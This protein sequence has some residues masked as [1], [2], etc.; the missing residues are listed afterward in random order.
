MLLIRLTQSV[1]QSPKD[2]QKSR[3]SFLTPF[4]RQSVAASQKQKATATHKKE[5][6]KVCALLQKT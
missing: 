3:Y 2:Y 6:Q 4:Y 5:L 1:N